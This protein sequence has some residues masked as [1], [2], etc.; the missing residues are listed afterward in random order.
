MRTLDRAGRSGV[1]AN[2]VGSE[3]ATELGACGLDLLEPFDASGYNRAIRGTS[4]RP[5]ETFGRDRPHAWLIGNTL[6]FWPS[7]L[8][9]LRRRERLRQHANPLDTYVCEAVSAFSE[10]LGTRFRTYLATAGGP[11]LVSMVRAA[12]VAGFACR[13]PS[14]LAIHTEYGP[15]FALRAVVVVDRTFAPES[16]EP[17]APDPCATC[18]APCVV[19]LDRAQQKTEAGVPE[20]GNIRSAWRDWVAVRDACPL[21]HPYRYDDEQI[22]Y[23]YTK[24]RTVLLRAAGRED[25]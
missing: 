11:D 15:W 6:K 17:N 9:A 22:R 23:H 7:F 10:A 12:Q 24:D 20:N 3:A 1:R 14:H 18:D 8:A 2:G 16:E 19:A 13:A 25:S 21:G 4:L 5:I